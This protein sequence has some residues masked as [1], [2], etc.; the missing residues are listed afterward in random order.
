MENIFLVRLASRIL[1]VIWPHCCVFVR[2]LCLDSPLRG[3]IP[4][5]RQ[6]TAWSWGCFLLLGILSFHRWTIIPFPL[7]QLFCDPRSLPL[8]IGLCLS[9]QSGYQD[10]YGK[11]CNRWDY[12]LF[13]HFWNLHSFDS[14]SEYSRRENHWPLI[15]SLR[16]THSLERLSRFGCRLGIAGNT[17]RERLAVKHDTIR[18]AEATDSR[19]AVLGSHH[20]NDDLI[21]GLE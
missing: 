9:A 14:A 11:Q 4:K 21:P 7:L 19:R 12:E 20:G 15:R 2:A 8:L 16:Q 10:Q 1:R 3:S 13:W 17:R 18:S 6:V 5:S